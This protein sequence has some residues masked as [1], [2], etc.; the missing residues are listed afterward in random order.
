MEVNLEEW[1]G[2]KLHKVTQVLLHRF[3]PMAKQSL[4]EQWAAGQFQG[5]Q[6][7][8]VLIRNAAALGQIEVLDRLIEMTLDEF[9][10]TIK[11]P[12]KS[13]DE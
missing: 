3:L 9:N 11:E 13:N 1:E 8:E 2:W 4:M 7:D 12:E 6:R 10:E 5:E